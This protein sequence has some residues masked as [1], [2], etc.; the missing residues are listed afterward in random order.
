MKNIIATALTQKRLYNFIS[1]IHEDYQE[2]EELI[3]LNNFIKAN[4]NRIY[5]WYDRGLI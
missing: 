5:L 2:N 3:D 1:C 4:E